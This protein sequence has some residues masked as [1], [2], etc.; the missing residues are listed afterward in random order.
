MEIKDH[1]VNL[2]NQKDSEASMNYASRGCSC[3]CAAIAEE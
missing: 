2:Y 3:T 1:K